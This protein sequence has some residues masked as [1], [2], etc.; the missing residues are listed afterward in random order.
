MPNDQPGQPATTGADIQHYLVR[1]GEV[2]EFGEQVAQDGAFLALAVAVRETDFLAR[3]QLGVL[4][5]ALKI[6]EADVP[7]PLEIFRAKGA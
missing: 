3:A 6:S 5:H 4:R 2:R 1:C 7:E